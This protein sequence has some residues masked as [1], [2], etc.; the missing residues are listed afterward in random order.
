MLHPIRMW[1]LSESD[2]Y[3]VAMKTRRS[4][5]LMQLLSAKSMMRYG[6]PK[7]TAG[8]ARSFVSGNSRS[9]APPASTMTMLSST[10][11]AM[12]G[13]SAPAEHDA[14]RGAVGADQPKRQAEHFVDPRLDVAKVQAF[15]DDR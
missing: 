4:P 12:A 13:R 1:R 3:C 6:P 14:R 11:A 10:S 15:D 9:P 5:E 7:Y 8:L 2:L